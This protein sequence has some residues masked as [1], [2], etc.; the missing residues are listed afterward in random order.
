MNLRGFVDGATITQDLVLKPD[1]CV[2]G[3]GAGGAIAAHTFA[4]AGYDVLVL[5][6]GGHYTQ[7]DFDMH[8]DT[9]F[10]H[11][12]QEDGGRSTADLG[13]AILQG[14]SV[15][16]STTVNWTTCFRTPEHVI[17][18][19]AQVHNVRG[20]TH[21][22]LTE[23]WQIVE[24]RLNIAEVPFELINANNRLLWAGCTALGWQRALIKRNVRGCMHSGYC[25]MGCPINAKR[26]MNLTYLPDAVAQGAVV[27]SRCR[28]VRFQF[29]GAQAR[30]LEAELLR[31][32][33][34]TPTGH[35]VRVQPKRFVLSA[36]SINGPALL[37]RS[38]FEA[39]GR[40]GARSFLHPTVAQLGT[41][42]DPVSGFYG[43]PQSVASHHFADRG[44][45]VGFI[46]EAAPIHPMLAALAAPGF[47]ADHAEALAKLPYTA[48]HIALLIDGFHPDEPGGQVKLRPSGAPLLDYPLPER[49]WRAMREASRAMGKLQLAAGAVRTSTPH[50]P[51]VIMHSEAE[52]KRLDDAPYALNRLTVFSAHAMGGL[53]LNDD[54]KKGVVSSDTM[55]LHG[56]E[57]VHVIDGSIFPTSLGVNPQLSIYGL[58]RLAASRIV[59]AGGL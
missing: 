15:G 44:D 41:F 12:Y 17:E 16:G 22:D 42:K 50:D 32:D 19:W 5:E 47:G 33:D 49:I 51:P 14:R 9:A 35:T 57:N 46:L 13:I 53:A 24:E 2:I 38:G 23:H 10:R 1:V 30:S 29:E 56:T 39:E 21:A 45:E 52:L 58:A 4:A 11:L 6:A 8:E 34:T 36:G 25:G 43:A 40:V 3:S 28:A 7:A 31:A 59:A 37:L 26:S 54:P 27:L 48:A 55:R 20:F 18:H